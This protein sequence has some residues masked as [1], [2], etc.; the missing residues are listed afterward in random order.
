MIAG[1]KFEGVE[2]PSASQRPLTLNKVTPGSM[3]SGLRVVTFGIGKVS[4]IEGV[5]KVIGSD[6]VEFPRALVSVAVIECERPPLIPITGTSNCVELSELGLIDHWRSPSS[7]LIAKE[8]GWSAETLSIAASGT[9]GLG[10]WTR[11]TWLIAGPVGLQATNKSGSS[12]KMSN[13]SENLMWFISSIP[14][15]GVER[16]IG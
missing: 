10:F 16:M 14:L 8:T 15:I 12:A 7:M 3:A 5:S 6:V 11:L 13:C 2:L 9:L 4:G 1:A